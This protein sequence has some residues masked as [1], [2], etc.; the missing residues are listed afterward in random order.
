MQ[1]TST[2]P[3]SQYPRSQE[4]ILQHVLNTSRPSR[5]RGYMRYSITQP[6]SRSKR[7]DR[8]GIVV[9]AEWSS[10]VNVAIYF[11]I[12]KEVGLLIYRRHLVEWILFDIRHHLGL[13]P[14]RRISTARRIVL[15]RRHSNQQQSD[16][17]FQDEQQQNHPKQQIHQRLTS[18]THTRSST[19]EC[20][21][22][23]VKLLQ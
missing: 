8:C 20:D 19:N 22:W 14:N 10:P 7:R 15:S 2:A 5:R 11:F 16:G 9:N 23:H 3:T 18:K 17:G 1:I 6:T 4:E 12:S 21:G 13:D